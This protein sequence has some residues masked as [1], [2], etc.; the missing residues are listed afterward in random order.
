MNTKALIRKN[1][2][3]KIITKQKLCV[4]QTTSGYSILVKVEHFRLKL[5]RFD[6]NTINTGNI[7]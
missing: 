3:K 4:E 7:H 5:K 2:A 1:F 6:L